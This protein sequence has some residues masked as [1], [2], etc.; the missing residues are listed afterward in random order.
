MIKV[1]RFQVILEPFAA[2]CD[3]FILGKHSKLLVEEWLYI[4]ETAYVGKFRS[5]SDRRKRTGSGANTARKNSKGHSFMGGP[6]CFFNALRAKSL[7]SPVE[8]VN[9]GVIVGP[10]G[11]TTKESG[12]I[13]GGI[14][15][16]QT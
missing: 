7:P 1:E 12:L 11:I 5:C 3:S 9:D 8:A 2:V 13:D 16:G 15:A 10:L 4:Y 6:C 14:P